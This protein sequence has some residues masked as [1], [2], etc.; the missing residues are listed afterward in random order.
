MMQFVTLQYD[1]GSLLVL[2]AEDARQKYPNLKT[3]H[4]EGK[5]GPYDVI[6]NM[7]SQSEEAVRP[8]PTDIGVA[9]LK[10]KGEFKGNV[11]D[12]MEEPGTVRFSEAVRISDMKQIPGRDMAEA[13][14]LLKSIANYFN[15]GNVLPVEQ[16]KHQVKRLQELL[17]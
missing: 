7:Q 10:A 6:V 15:P 1:R 4:T 11:P 12:D 8:M 14:A 16:I 5:G 13:H 3:T 2:A 9:D 17:S